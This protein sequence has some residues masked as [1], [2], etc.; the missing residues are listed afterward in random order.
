MNFIQ[1]AHFKQEDE[2]SCVPTSLA[3]V[4]SVYIISLFLPHSESDSLH[5]VVV[6]GLDQESVYINDPLL[7]AS[8]PFKMTLSAFVEAWQWY[9]YCMISIVPSEEK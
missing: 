1:K 9:N 4:L 3:M 5:A 7:D 6:V 2:V 8:S